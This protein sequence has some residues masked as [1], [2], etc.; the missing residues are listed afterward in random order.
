MLLERIQLQNLL[1]FGP[2]AEEIELGPLNV[3]IGPNGSGKSNFIEAIGLLQAAPT[4][5]AAPMRAGRGVADWI[6]QG[7]PK[8]DSARIEVVVKPDG[9]KALHYSVEFGERH[10]RLAVL[11]EQLKRTGKRD[12]TYM[13]TS[14]GKTFIRARRE[15]SEVAERADAPY[16]HVE[17]PTEMSK[18]V[19]AQVKDAKHHPEL[20]CLGQQLERICLYREWTLGPNNAVRVPQR[21]DLPNVPLAEGHGNLGLVL[22]RLSRDAKVRQRIV[23]ALRALYSEAS[24]FHVNIEF[25]TVQLFIQERNGNVSVPATR[26]SDGTI[27]YLSLLAI[28]CDPKPPPLVCIEEPELGLHPDVLPGLAELLLE[29]SERCQLIVTTHSDVLVDA[30]TEEPECVVVCEKEGGQTKLKR[31]SQSELG[32]WLEKYRLGELWSSGEIGGNRWLPTSPTTSM[33]CS[34]IARAL[35][36]QPGRGYT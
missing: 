36:S 15:P 16:M 26:L 1:S 14:D 4:D 19:L 25:N 27:R 5:L 28:L 3:L 10:Q 17:Y 30:L 22:N 8:A 21:T 9:E 13:E 23:D 2:D 6:W 33:S 32:H 18:S 11:N 7:E 12:A 34:S 24:D 29:A 20:T 31:L 35:W